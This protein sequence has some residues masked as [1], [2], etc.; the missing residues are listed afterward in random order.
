MTKKA[1]VLEDGHSKI[2]IEED[3]FNLRV[4]AR[5]GEGLGETFVYESATTNE[6]DGCSWR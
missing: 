6:N 2:I 4:E 5:Q 1:I 3:E